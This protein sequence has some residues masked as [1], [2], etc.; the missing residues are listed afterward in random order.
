MQTNFRYTAM[1][2][3]LA[4]MPGGIAMLIMMPIAGQVSGLHR[5]RNI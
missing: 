4:L 2:S 1:L 3:G 5:S